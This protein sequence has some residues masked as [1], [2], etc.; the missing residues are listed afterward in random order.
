VTQFV[1]NSWQNKTTKQMPFELLIGYTP[2]IGPIKVRGKIS[3]VNRHKEHLSEKRNQAKIA[4][5]KA[6]AFLQKYNIRK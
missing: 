4:I 3:N 5:Q 6:Q 1:H 2:T